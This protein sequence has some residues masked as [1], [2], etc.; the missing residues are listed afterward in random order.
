MQA[1]TSTGCKQ[2][3]AA[4]LE[5][6]LMGSVV[7]GDALPSSLMLR[8]QDFADP[9]CRRLFVLTSR[10]EAGRQ[11]IDLTGVCMEDE[12]LDAQEVVTIV[13]ERCVSDVL[14]AQH[15]ARLRE[16][17]IRRRC[18]ALLCETLERMRAGEDTRGA[19]AQL[20]ERIGIE[21]AEVS[22]SAGGEDMMTLMLRVLD[23]MGQEQEKTEPIGTGIG[24]LDAC[25]TGGFRPGDLAVVAALTSVGKSAMLAFMMRSAAGQGKRVLLVS[26]EMS[27][28]Q[29]AE[30][31]MASIGR[32]PLDGII[33][34]EALSEEQAVRLSEGMDLY[35][36][37]KIIVI[38]SGT[39]T[40]SSV[41]RAALKMKLGGGLDMIVVDYLQR[42]RPDRPGGSKAEEVG[43][44]A[45]GL[46]SMAVDLGVPVLTAAQFNR[47][48]A[49]ARQEARG[50]ETEGVPA[51][52]QLR[53]SSQIEDEANTVIVLD[54]PQRARTG[55]RMINAHVVKNRSGALGAIQLRFDARTMTY[56]PRD[57][58]E[59][60]G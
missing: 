9:L 17:T 52:H 38:S 45:A 55:D 46:K 51:L 14:L 56:Y 35:H 8:E 6:A 18:E 10:M 40:V 5:R 3:S 13:S 7:F 28:E 60:A 20:R 32:I 53:D 16:R 26:C 58:K 29:N 44:I 54:E 24:K 57:G 11:A 1:K 42:L 25:L 50:R 23:Q 36:P 48:A 34:R 19:M 33:R 37:E 49:R 15:S 22:G 21:M 27:D 4:M 47:E 12:T 41:R 39:Q 43:A 59:E 2:E 31:Y 30:R